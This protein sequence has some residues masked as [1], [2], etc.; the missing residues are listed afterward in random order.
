MATTDVARVGR[1]TVDRVEERDVD[2]MLLE[3][4]VC[5]PAFQSFV[6]ANVLGEGA[7]LFDEA[8]NSVSS[9][10]HG[11]SDLIAVYASCERRI[12]VMIENKIAAN[13]MPEQAN[14]YRLRGQE[15]IQEGLWGEFVTVLLAPRRYLEADHHGHVF[16]RYIAYEDLLTYFERPS[17]GARG[18][19]RAAV[20]RRACSGSKASVYRRVPDAATTQFF[21]DYFGLASREYAEL[22]M[23]RDPDRP[24]K[25]TWVRFFPDAGLPK[26]VSVYHKAAETFAADISF[27]R[28]RVE[29]LHAA[30]GDKIEPDMALEQTS[31][32][33]VIRIRTPPLSVHQGLADQL[34][35]VRAGLDACR[36]LV[37]FFE[38]HGDA[39][40]R[41]PHR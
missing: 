9:V 26:H 37:S 20:L 1:G 6:A 27:A 30:I 3:E 21:H 39:L 40:G 14:R 35:E 4:L 31:A 36:R 38:R 33:A 12:A 41:V 15:G 13:F 22:R 2:L 17:L 23:R 7:W 25:S 34:P 18:E 19:W 10:S 29:D 32:S 8:F 5:E 11:E 16:D 28:T 24:A